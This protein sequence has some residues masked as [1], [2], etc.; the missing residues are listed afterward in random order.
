[1]RR[2]VVQ[3]WVAGWNQIGHAHNPDVV[4][5]GVSAEHA[6]DYIAG[7]IAHVGDFAASEFGG[8]EYSQAWNEVQ[9]WNTP[10]GIAELEQNA[11]L[12]GGCGGHRSVHVDGYDYWVIPCGD[13]N[14]DQIKE[15]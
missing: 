1:M 13:P 6:I 5:H 12:H 9:D 14:C 15:K 4:L 2:Y 11:A 7:E 8:R 10:E 3:H